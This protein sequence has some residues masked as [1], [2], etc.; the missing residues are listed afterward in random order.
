MIVYLNLS[1]D[2]SVHE[3]TEYVHDSFKYLLN[4][5]QNRNYG[6]SINEIAAVAV[7]TQKDQIQYF[8]FGTS[9][10]YKKKSIGTVLNIDIDIA[11]NSTKEELYNL[12]KDLFMQ[13]CRNYRNLKIK[14]FDLDLFLDDLN[15]FFSIVEKADAKKLETLFEEINEQTSEVVKQKWSRFLRNK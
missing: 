15:V 12:T 8:G 13:E 14:D 6:S 10:S 4:F 9:R 11:K 7:I 5:F 2:I 1:F 3:K